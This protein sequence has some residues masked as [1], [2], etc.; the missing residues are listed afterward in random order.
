MRI[1]LFGFG[2]AGRAV[3][4]VLLQSDEAYLCWVIRKSKL[5]QHRSVSE[6]LGIPEDAGG[7]GLIFPIEEWPSAKLFDEHPVDVIDFSSAETVL[8]YGGSRKRGIA[9]KLQYLFIRLN[10]RLFKNYLSKHVLL[11]SQHHNWY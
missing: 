8:S 11:F 2:R 3:A 9:I 1:G 6:F 4:T 10:E 7:Q 5:L